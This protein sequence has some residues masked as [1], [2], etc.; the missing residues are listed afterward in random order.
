MRLSLLPTTAIVWSLAATTAV[1][2]PASQV[3]TDVPAGHWAE[4][5]VTQ[6]AVDRAFMTGY[7]D[8]TFRG[9]LPFTRLQL[10]LAMNEL[11]KELE[12]LT[13]TSWATEGL[14]GYQ[15]QDLPAD[16]ELRQIVLKLANQ[17][18]LFEGVPGVTSNTLGANKQVTRF[19]MAKVVDRLMRLGEAKGVVDPSVQAPQIYTF[20]DLS[21]SAWAYN[22]VKQVSD[23]YQVMIGFPDGTFRGREELTRYQFA[24][25]A[26]QTFPLVRELV[27]KTQER[28]EEQAAA[29]APMPAFQQSHPLFL[30]VTGRFDGPIGPS[31]TARYAHY[32]GNFF[33]LAEAEL[34]LQTAASE[35]LYNGA[36]SLGY[37]LP[38]GQ[39]FHLQPYLG[40]RA[41]SN[42]T[43]T[44]GGV[45]YGAV[46]YLRPTAQ[47][48]FF[49]NANGTSLLSGAAQGGFLGGATVGAEYFI[50]ENFGL[51]LQGGYQLLPNTLS[52]PTAALG[53]EPATTGTV[54]VNLRF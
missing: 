6:V 20:S 10:A 48:G 14:G 40:G 41:F 17:Y 46:G 13:K 15:F 33:A 36:L 9:E 54:G 26:S 8:G 12:T 16:S 1:A 43:N 32:M 31:G 38:L 37:A 7:A 53:T 2:A 29:V 35:R 47:W 25:S 18:R 45:T 11:I 39:A 30:G 3:F 51:T 44:V 49:A 28:Q 52:T 19:E 23:R 27:E 21:P 24:A 50:T 4:Q 22:E 42:M 34:G 5:A